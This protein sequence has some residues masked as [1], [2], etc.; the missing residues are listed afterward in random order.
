MKRILF[1][2]DERELFPVMSKIFS[3]ESYRVVCAADGLEGLQKYRNEEFDLIISDYRMPKVDGV[4]FYQQIRDME[5]SRKQTATPI[6]FVSAW[7]DEIQAKKRQWDSCDFLNKPYQVYEL[8]QKASK[9]LGTQ[10][11]T[12][13]KPE[14]KIF[15]EPGQVLFDEGDLSKEMYYIVSGSLGAFKKNAQGEEIRVGIV[16]TG[17]L[18]GEMS[19]I[20][21]LPRAAK[22]VA[23]EMTELVTIPPDRILTLLQDQ[24][25]WIR[26]M[27][28][29][30]SKRLRE[31]LKQVG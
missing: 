13:S 21:D 22:L 27:L 24:P 15:L 5:N 7:S 18:V 2:D 9:L 23:L 4:R 12:E 1:I 19:L 30:L 6:L 25:K 11:E 31:T 26:L 3:K 8:V 10:S 17:E 20:D 29:T 28:E 14:S 16:G